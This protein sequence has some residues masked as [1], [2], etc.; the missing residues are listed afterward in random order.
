MITPTAA[1]SRK[2]KHEEFY[3]CRNG[4]ELRISPEEFSNVLKRI[5]LFTEGRFDEMEDV[6][7]TPNFRTYLEKVIGILPG[8]CLATAREIGNSKGSARQHRSK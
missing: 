8:P 4:I 1:N 3:V 6:P 2:T 7:P 5:Y